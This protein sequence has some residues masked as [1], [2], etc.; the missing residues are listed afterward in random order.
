MRRLLTPALLLAVAAPLWAPATAAAEDASRRAYRP[1]RRAAIVSELPS[2]PLIGPAQ[3]ATAPRSAADLAPVPNR[4]IEAPVQRSREQASL[5]PDLMQRNLPGRSPGQAGLENR[6]EDR[7][8][9]P[10]PGA[11]LRLPFSF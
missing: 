2:L 10:G 3:A 4:E 1:Q 8:F 9:T 11:R 7:L 6:R 5:M